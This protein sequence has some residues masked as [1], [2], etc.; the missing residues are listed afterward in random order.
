M[1]L[2]DVLLIV[3]GVG[4]VL[5][6][7]GA[8]FQARRVLQRR[9]R[10]HE[11]RAVVARYRMLLHE[12]LQQELLV[13]DEDD[14]IALD[15]LPEADPEMFV[16]FVRPIEKVVSEIEP[17]SGDYVRAALRIEYAEEGQS[18]GPRP[19]Q[20]EPHLRLDLSLT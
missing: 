13:I 8:A 14:F 1:G 18:E 5:V 2:S 4:S 12:W 10:A 11:T 7:V 16:H 3:V 19:R 17:S 20:A 6:A 9:K 15:R